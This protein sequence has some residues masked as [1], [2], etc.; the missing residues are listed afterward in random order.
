MIM[1]LVGMQSHAPTDKTCSEM[2]SCFIVSD[3]IK[4]D[5]AIRVS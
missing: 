5:S 3:I 4:I 1:G 2:V